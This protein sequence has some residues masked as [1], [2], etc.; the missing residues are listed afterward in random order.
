MVATYYLLFDLFVLHASD[1]HD[2]DVGKGGGGCW[3]GPYIHIKYIDTIY[4]ISML[5]RIWNH[6]IVG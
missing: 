1:D 4:L 5:F 6:A 3:P 2:H